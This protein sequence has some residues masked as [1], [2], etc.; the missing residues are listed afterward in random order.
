MFVIKHLHLH[1]NTMWADTTTGVRQKVYLLR[2][3]PPLW[4]PKAFFEIVYDGKFKLRIHLYQFEFEPIFVMCSIHLL[5]VLSIYLVSQICTC[6]SNLCLCSL[7]S[8]P[9][10]AVSRHE[11]SR[12]H[13]IH[14]AFLVLVG[15]TQFS[16]SLP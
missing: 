3:S 1:R 9:F 7:F 11:E 14:V 12:F 15:S 13:R 5:C 16:G 6:N 4:F 2:Y 8:V 10:F